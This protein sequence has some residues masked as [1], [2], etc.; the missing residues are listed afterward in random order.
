MPTRLGKFLSALLPAALLAGCVSLNPLGPDSTGPEPPPP[1][2]VVDTTMPFAWGFSTSSYQYEDPDVHEG[3]PGWFRTDWDDFVAAGHAPPKGNALY[4]WSH[5]DKDLEALRASGVTHYRFS[6][7]WPRIE[8][9]RGK[10][11]E[12]AIRGYV[13]MARL[14]RE[15]GIEPVVCLWHFTFPGWLYDRTDPKASNWLHPDARTAWA[16]FLDTVLP[17]LAPYVD[18][19][20]PQNEPNGQITTAYI[21]GQWPPGMSLAFG[22]YWKAID[23]STAMFR[24]AARR[25][26]SVKP[27]AKVVAIEALPWWDKSGFDPG[28]LIFNTMVHGNIDHLDRIWDVCD[29]IGINYY[30]SQKAG[31][32]SL[33]SES[34]R[35]GHDF[36]MMGWRIDPEGLLKQIRRVGARYGKPMM[37]TENGIATPH[38]P[39]RIN[40]IREHLAAVGTAIAEGWDVRGYFSWSLADNYEWHYGYKAL[41]GLS[42]MDPDTLDRVPK[43]SM[44]FY[45]DTI[46]SNPRIGSV[47]E[48]RRASLGDSAEEGR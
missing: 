27:S 44:A 48:L 28:A 40:Y 6:I 32:F 29:I 9:E 14:L 15:A 16:D 17:R 34:R 22:T 30:Y 31:V 11:N 19:F 37:I 25:I 4:S 13:R 20:A 35:R 12:E 23:A 2:S 24:D 26:K 18:W 33:L 5:F 38:D 1:R 36:T 21:V 46:R 41:F 47:A 43:P 10:Y 45:R 7:S 8:P 3:G 42:H 39:K